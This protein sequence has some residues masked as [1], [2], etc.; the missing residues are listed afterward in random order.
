M[1]GV[2]LWEM[3]TFGEEPWIGLNGSQILRK[4]DREGER[5]H[6][7]DA[8][9]ESVYAIL[10][11]CWARSPTDR[12]TFE[13]LKDFLT[14]TAPPV[15]RITHSFAEEGKMATERGDTVVVVDGASGDYWWRGQN[16][17][18]FDIG[19]FP[20]KI[21]VD[22]GGKKA[23]DISKP[24]KSSFIHAGHGHPGGEQDRSWG[25]PA[26]IE[27]ATLRRSARAA[28]EQQQQPQHQGDPGGSPRTGKLT[29]RQMRLRPAPTQP[30]AGTDSTATAAAARP[31]IPP[32]GTLVRPS[33]SSNTLAAALAL[34][35]P[36][37]HKKEE[38][39]IDLSDGASTYQKTT[40]PRPDLRGQSQGQQPTSNLSQQ[41]RQLKQ[42]QQQS[43]RHLLN[44][45][46]VT[47]N[48]QH[49]RGDSILDAPIDVPQ[50][51]EEVED[52][53]DDH[54]PRQS[55]VRED[56]VSE[57]TY[58]NY[59]VNR[60]HYADQSFLSVHS[61]PTQPQQGDTSFDSL[62]PGETY[63]M[64]PREDDH[65]EEEEEGES[66]PDPF[67][68]SRV[69]IPAERSSTPNAANAS[70]TESVSQAVSQLDPN[71]MIFRLMQS[72]S[73]GPHQT[74][75]SLNVT[76]SAVPQLTS[77]LSPPAFN[78]ADVVLGSNE[79]IAGLDSPAPN[80]GTSSVPVA[81]PPPQINMAASMPAPGGGSD[82]FNWLERTMKRDLNIGGKEASAP[83]SVIPTS[84]AVATANP[85]EV[86][87]MASTNPW[88]PAGANVFQFPPVSSA[89][90]PPFPLQ[91][92]AAAFPPQPTAVQPVAVGRPQ[93]MLYA[94]TFTCLPPAA[95][96]GN[97]QPTASLAV[98]PLQPEKVRLHNLQQQ[99][100]KKL[101]MQMQHQQTSQVQGGGGPSQGQQPTKTFDKEFI[102]DLEKDL[103]LKE[104]SLNLMPP[105]PSVATVRAPPALAP[106]PAP[107]TAAAAGTSPLV[108][109]LLP[110]PPNNA[111]AGLSRRMSNSMS[112]LNSSGAATSSPAATVT[113]AAGVTRKPPPR[114]APPM[115]SSI[116]PRGA[117]ARSG[118]SI[119]TV[120]PLRVALP[121]EP[122]YSN[123]GAAA[124]SGASPRTAHVRPFVGGSYQQQQQQQQ[125]GAMGD[126]GARSANWRPLNTGGSRSSSNSGGGTPHYQ[127][128]REDSGASSWEGPQQQRPINHLEVNKIAQVGKMVPG[129]S[130]SQCRSALESVNWDT[131]VAIK[132]LKIDKLYRIG[133]ADRPTCE[134]TLAAV[135]WDLERAAGM[136]L[137]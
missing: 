104:A 101:Q 60:E 17:R 129:V 102:A 126:V 81:Q 136:L 29:T 26:A 58:S 12:P 137:E 85:S 19:D 64:P 45:G 83:L 73:G 65:Q 76:D 30:P 122:V 31:P 110:P 107:T 100:Q 75:N 117:G 128:L 109:G 69:V 16:Q 8:C 13:A 124:A 84:A 50:Q 108:P 112:S 38:S 88:G 36:T 1:F 46:A 135:G 97:S 82:A 55:E 62:P 53:E 111:R 66:G 133:V 74:P 39:L 52:E 34:E 86:Q 20:S 3:F 72:S 127:P 9:P 98:Q 92:G 6:R 56:V 106:V 44:P 49:Q 54:H 47:S 15:M 48:V 118:A 77:P 130:A 116:S 33:P 125:Q 70:N 123:T 32:T 99:Q 25:H 80:R 43:P 115:V 91:G 14:E 4:I 37:H 5:L 18:T 96:A 59:P 27:E 7:P 57:H 87:P 95:Q 51:E 113:Q 131:S 11:Q 79:A 119:N 94:P 121:D 105:S 89:A 63:H 68:T 71:S 22:V 21:A 41:Q 10:V 78:P 103:G 114:P 132:N 28:S 23:K 134:K 24:L 35:S 61:N 67:D 2:T 42:Q 120:A 90:A 93:S 40:E